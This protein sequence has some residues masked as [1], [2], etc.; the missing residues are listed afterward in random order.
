MALEKK[1]GQTTLRLPAELCAEL[2]AISAHTGITVTALLL[3]AIW[4]S[5]LKLRQPPQ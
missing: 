5:V 1:R 4:W 3:G 2:K